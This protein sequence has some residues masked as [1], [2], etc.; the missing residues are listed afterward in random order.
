MYWLKLIKKNLFKVFLK[1][2]FISI[3]AI[4]FVLIFPLNAADNNEIASNKALDGLTASKSQIEEILEYFSESIQNKTPIDTEKTSKMFGYKN[5]EEFANQYLK[6]F[7]LTDITVDEIREYLEGT[8][9]TVIIDQSKKNIDKLYKLIMNDEYFKKKNTYLKTYKKGVHKGNE[10]NMMAL[11][12]YVN[13]EKEMAKITKNPNLKKISRFTWWWGVTWGNNSNPYGYALK[14][15]RESAE[16]Y[17][18]FGGKCIIVDWRSKKT[19]EIKNMIKPD[20]ELA[21][22]MKEL[23]NKKIKKEKPKIEVEEK[24]KIANINIPVQVFLVKYNQPNFKSKITSNEVKEDFKKANDIWNRRGL[25]FEIINISNVKGSSKKISK[26]LKWVE[27]KYVKSLQIDL[28][29]QT[30]KSK[31]DKKYDQIVQKIIGAKKN[32]NKNAINVFY[33]PHIPSGLA[34]GVAYTYALNKK[35]FAQLDQLRRQNLGFIIIGEKSACISRGRTVAHELGHMFSLGHKH[36]Q[37]TDLMMWGSGIEIQNWQLQKFQ[38]YH[39]KYLRK[40]LTF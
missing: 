17:K 10:I 18:L 16:K 22:R 15:C 35:Y 19:G 1:K 36:D 38:K 28:K 34:C 29:K 3:F 39:N 40:R 31:N 9:S 11:A 4:Y 27:S 7:K 32:R 12:V 6:I 26:D 30:M 24:I 13:Y 5:F 21:Q 23:K 37:K 20:V 14:G 33:I 8:D 25:N 2:I